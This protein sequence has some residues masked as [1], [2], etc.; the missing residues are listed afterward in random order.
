MSDR[1]GT[2]PDRAWRPGARRTSWPTKTTTLGYS[3]ERLPN[4][5]T[6]PGLDEV[7][8]SHTSSHVAS[9][10]STTAGYNQTIW[11]GVE[12]DDFARVKRH[13]WLE[14]DGR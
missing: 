3:G 5:I 11:R 1:T 4:R 2:C 10:V 14:V 13:Q 9:K 12:Q 6:F 8:R 7:T